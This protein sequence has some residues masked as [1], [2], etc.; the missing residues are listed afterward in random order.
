MLYVVMEL[1][2]NQYRKIEEKLRIYDKPFIDISLLQKIID[3]FAP[4][5]KVFQLSSRGL[6]SPIKQWELYLNKTYREYV[7]KQSILW[8][9]ME[10]KEYMIGGLYLYN[11]YWYTTQLADRTTVY[12]TIY[13][14]QRAVAWAKFIFH[15]VRSSFFR[16]K[17]RKESQ[18]VYYYTMSPER[19]LIQLIKD[20]KWRLEFQE[21]IAYKIRKGDLDSKKILSLCQKYC[22]KNTQIL[23]DSFLKEC[24][25]I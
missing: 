2:I 12:N 11:Q 9:Y 4:N 21:D 25:K 16:W 3:K 15:K 5:Y 6:I 10:G 8:K 24:S 17:E 7:S 13:S 14:G 1:P 22:S 23:V 18:W 19:A 20:N